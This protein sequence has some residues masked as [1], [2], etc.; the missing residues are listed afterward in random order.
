M[1]IAGESYGGFRVARLARTLQEDHGVS[2]SAAILISPGI[3]LSTLVPHDYGI[4]HF[5]ELFPSFAATAHAMPVMYSPAGQIR[6]FQSRSDSAS[7][8]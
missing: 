2:L 4:E 7:T 6:S 8:R 3:E 1:A 5:I